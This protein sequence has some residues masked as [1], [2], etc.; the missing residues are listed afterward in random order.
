[1]TDVLTPLVD[2]LFAIDLVQRHNRSSANALTLFVAQVFNAETTED[3]KPMPSKCLDLTVLKMPQPSDRCGGVLFTLGE[4]AAIAAK[5]EFASAEEVRSDGTA[6]FNCVF[7][8]SNVAL[9]KRWLTLLNWP[10]KRVQ[11]RWQTHTLFEQTYCRT[12]TKTSCCQS[13]R[14]GTIRSRSSVGRYH[15][16]WQCL[17]EQCLVARRVRRARRLRT[18]YQVFHATFGLPVDEV[19][20]GAFSCAL[21]TGKKALPGCAVR[22]LCFG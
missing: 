8:C 15:D 17:F 9:N 22:F 2:D 6:V 20:F 7:G 10:N 19:P 14:I 5:R 16:R 4:S 1:M 12:T 18:K 3:G 21:V 11:H 13:E